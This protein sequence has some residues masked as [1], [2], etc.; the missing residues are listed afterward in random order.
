MRLLHVYAGPFPSHQG[1]QA[2][3]AQRLAAQA[4]R[5]HRVTLRCWSG[6][7][8]EPPTG[9]EI[10]RLKPMPGADR[11]SSGPHPSRARLALAL[12]RAV[13]RDLREGF[14]I[15]HAH[16]VEAPIL[17]RLRGARPLIHHVHTSLAEE[18]PM[19]GGD[20]VAMRGA[21]WLLDRA[22]ARAADG[23]LA[24]SERGARL[25]RRW[26]ARL[27]LSVPPGIPVIEADPRRARE[28][29]DLSGE[30][31][32]YTGNLDAYQELDRLIEAAARFDLPVLI[33]TGDD[34]TELVQRGRARGA[35][36]LRALR[37]RDFADHRDLLAAA[38]LSVVPRA[39]CA[40]VPVKLLNALAVG[41]PVV[42]I[43]GAVD[44]W[45]GTLAADPGELGAVLQRTSADP[46]LVDRLA[47]AARD[48]AA[49]LGPDH[50]AAEIDAFQAHVLASV[51]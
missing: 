47:D 5:G 39:R 41:T 16:H 21:G 18:L 22:C 46:V 27:A 9:V 38:R 23:T 48:A 31:I 24:L 14:D 43:R 44:A 33:A 34:P 29:F 4:A 50:R 37:T 30:E 36:R 28:A 2:A 12:A 20:A 6:G 7:Q 25:A 15:V 8:G 1:T 26:G 11:M 45:P 40:G 17:A 35:H 49:R 51:T 13:R 42:V 32:V 10:R 3:I 19:Y